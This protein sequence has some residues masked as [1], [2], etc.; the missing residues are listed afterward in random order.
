MTSCGASAVG[1]FLHV[2]NQRF[3]VK[4]VSY[5]TFAPRVTGDQF[6]DPDTVAADFALMAEAG[7]NTV[8][9]YTAP[10]TALLDEAARLGLRVIATVPWMQHVAFLDDRKTCRE[11]RDGVLAHVRGIAN[12]PALLLIALGNE[13]PPGIVRWHGR[14]RVQRFLHD[15][16]ADAKA[17]APET[18]LTYVNYPPTDY[19]DLSCFDVC[20]FNVYLHREAELRNYLRRLQHIA[21][22]KPLLLA[23]AGADSL[24]EGETGQA[25][26][27][28]MQ[29]RVAFEEGF[30][31]AIAF[32]WTDEWWR[33]GSAIEDWAFGL[34]DAERTPKLALHA[35][36]HVFSSVPFRKEQQRKWPLVS[37][38]VCAYNA[39]TTLEECLSAL[40]RL[41]YPRFEVIVIDDGSQ[42]RTAAIARNHA[43][44]KL[45]STG[46]AGLSQARNIGLAH[47]AGEIVAYTD[48]DVAVDPDW[49]NY[50]IQPFLTSE[51]V[52]V[53]GPNVVPPDDPWIAQ[54]V[55]RAPGAPTH[56][57]LDDRIAEHIPG[58]NMAFR[59]EALLAVD[60]FNPIFVRAGDDVD[61]CWRLQARGWKL[62]Y[63][64][65]ALVWHR[66]RP[67]IRAYW[68]QQVGYGEGEAWLAN[69]HPERVV[70][71]RPLWQGHIY[72][73]LPFVRSFAQTRINAGVWGTAQ[74]PSVY[75]TD[76]HPFAYLPHRARWQL[77]SIAL[78]SAGVLLVATGWAP[79][80]GVGFLVAGLSALGVTLMRCVGYARASAIESLPPIAGCSVAISRLVY[81][82]TIAGLHFVHPMARLWGRLRGMMA[83]PDGR[84]DETLD[85]LGRDR[86]HARRRSPSMLS[87]GAED[88]RA[89]LLLTVG[90]SLERQF[91]CETWQQL[92]AILRGVTDRLRSSRAVSL[93]EI[94][95]GWRA[96][97]DVSVSIGG[98]AWVHL[99][100]LIEDHGGGKCLLRV[101]TR[102]RPTLVGCLAIALLAGSLGI[103]VAMAADPPLWASASIAGALVLPL[104]AAAFRRVAGLCAVFRSAVK[105]VVTQAGMIPLQPAK[106]SQQEVRKRPTAPVRLGEG[107]TGEAHRISPVRRTARVTKLPSIPHEPLDESSSHAAHSGVDP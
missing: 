51:V 31:G 107:A 42:D 38:V 65:S 72:S 6:P 71:G 3:L 73:P 55:A 102:L 74:F 46:N 61:L 68:R 100:A 10:T 21:G 84:H 48:A 45:V 36:S 54:C 105:D 34:V 58:C 85:S 20:A 12:H 41:T 59:R 24:R 7:I 44:V 9:T 95:D 87:P 81:R 99:R 25:A 78:V 76:V 52:G 79:G 69:C 22:N 86:P 14:I 1:K 26:L 53:G 64:P 62:G 56:V 27:T 98:L 67:T 32:A 57:M 16:Y 28:S 30:C 94:D 35:V 4:G 33:G 89:A 93:I 50:L 91:W 60:G 11:I 92:D 97:R 8:R 2:G 23:E 15:L 90:R 17:V 47:A 80:V 103:F 37:V 49:L 13:I 106:Q 19:L 75:R 39:Q 5:G 82:A 88:L 29:L 101:S 104:I 66:H 96:D 77:L 40:E 18:L 63:A 43:S 83:V 70:R